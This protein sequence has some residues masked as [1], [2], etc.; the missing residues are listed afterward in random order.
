MT[1]KIAFLGFGEAARAFCDSMG[2]A[3][4]GLAFTAYDLK[5]GGP[6]DGAIRAAMEARGVA[7][8]DAAAALGAADVVFSAAR[9]AVSGSL[10]SPGWERSR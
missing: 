9:D 2:E 6:E 3:D 1:R 8:R 5:L 10:W 7:A 4:A